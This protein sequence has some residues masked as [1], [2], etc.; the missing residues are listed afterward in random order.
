[1]ARDYEHA[2]KSPPSTAQTPIDV[3][4]KRFK[5]ELPNHTERLVAEIRV[6][7]Y[8]IRT[9]QSYLGW[10]ERYVHFHGMR[11]PATLDGSAISSYLEHLVVHRH[12]SASTQSQALNALIFFT[13]M[14]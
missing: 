14:Y 11:D 3:L 4:G 8:S 2:S 6:R 10:L 7:Q 1:M 9:E 5:Q 12:V 13:N